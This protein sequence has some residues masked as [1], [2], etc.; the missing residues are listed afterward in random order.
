MNILTL[1]NNHSVT[2]NSAEE[3]AVINY[4]CNLI[5]WNFI[6][7]LYYQGALAGSEFLTYNA[8]KI[9]IC[10]N[11]IFGHLAGVTATTA[12][13]AFYDEANVN[14]FAVQDNGVLWDGAAPRYQLQSL[15]F[16][17]LFFSRITTTAAITQMRFIGYRLTV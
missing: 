5:N 9:Y 8:G 2:V 4:A 6:I 15:T 10:T 11:V 7:P 1:K 3:I 13:A 16:K 12:Y 17:N 14:N